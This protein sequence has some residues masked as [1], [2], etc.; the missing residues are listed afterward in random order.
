M[1]TIHTLLLGKDARR[2]CDHRG[3]RGADA[4]TPDTANQPVFLPPPYN[5]WPP[6][7][8][9]TPVEPGGPIRL[10]GPE[11]AAVTTGVLKWIKDPVSVRLAALRAGANTSIDGAQV[12]SLPKRD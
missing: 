1:P 6:A 3:L 4:C 12:I 7:P 8:P 2:S 9:G 5:A 11:Q 10:D